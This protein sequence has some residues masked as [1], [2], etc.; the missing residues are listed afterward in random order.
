MS[1]TQQQM[2]LLSLPEEV[3]I[4]IIIYIF[5]GP[6]ILDLDIAQP[7]HAIAR[8]S[9]N[10]LSANRRLH[11]LAKQILRSNFTR[12]GLHVCSITPGPK[13]AGEDKL[14]SFLRQ[15]GDCFR[16]VSI[17]DAAT[18][19]DTF[20]K[21]LLCLPNLEMLTFTAKGLEF[22]HTLDP[23]DEVC[24]SGV[25]SVERVRKLC[26]PAAEWAMYHVTG[27]CAQLEIWGLPKWTEAGIEAWAIEGLKE[28]EGRFS[29]A[30]DVVI[31]ILSREA[32]GP[33]ALGRWV[34]SCWCA[35][36]IAVR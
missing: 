5:S 32:E 8:Q 3:I 12:S 35:D 22:N 21:R 10:I 6:C 18:R 7:P 23:D 25:L 33:R 36:L 17:V 24:T 27:R 15:Y 16:E 20:L 28:R 1:E 29:I 31:C 19:D 34:S 14:L 9:I 13:D 2:M 26:G 4:Q 11:I 30:L